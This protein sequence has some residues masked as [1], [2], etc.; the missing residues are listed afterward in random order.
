MRVLI[1]MKGLLA[2][3]RCR[4]REEQRADESSVPRA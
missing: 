3:F 2:S 1:F 4:E